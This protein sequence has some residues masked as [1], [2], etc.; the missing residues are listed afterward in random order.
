MV[1]RRHVSGVAAT[2][3]TRPPDLRDPAA[4]RYT[5][6]APV[7]LHEDCRLVPLFKDDE[8]FYP[9]QGNLHAIIQDI[10]LASRALGEL[11][12][13]LWITHRLVSPTWI[14]SFGRLPRMPNA[15]ALISKNH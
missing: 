7:V 3:S 1:T 10:V 9:L 6:K 12:T 2:A 14:T 11:A 13:C 5:S 15:F 8:L 4:G